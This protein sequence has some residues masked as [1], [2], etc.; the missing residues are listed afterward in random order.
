MKNDEQ[1]IFHPYLWRMGVA[2]LVIGLIILKITIGWTDPSG[3]APNVSG[4]IK[5]G[6]GVNSGNIGIGLGS[7]DQPAST[8]SV[9]GGLSVG[10]SY[11]DKAALANNVIIQGSLSV[12]TTTE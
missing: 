1:K 3:S 10:S 8:L 4:G 2:L 9:K 6:I 7:A 5:R 11:I 12:G